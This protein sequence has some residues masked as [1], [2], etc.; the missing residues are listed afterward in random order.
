M[1]IKMLKTTKGATNR[2]GI[3]IMDYLENQTYDV[4][5]ELALVFLD[6]NLA[7]LPNETVAEQKE[8]DLTEIETKEF[9]KSKKTK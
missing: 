8:L 1:L 3:Y 5:D 2:L 4:F 6:N 7:V 9:K